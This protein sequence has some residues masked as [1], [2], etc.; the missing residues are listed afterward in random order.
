MKHLKN[1]KIFES[2]D[3]MEFARNIYDLQN[4]IND[5]FFS[6]ISDEDRFSVRVETTS[7]KNKTWVSISLSDHMD[8]EGFRLGEIKDFL[9]RLKG[10]LGDRCGKVGILVQGE[11]ERID[12]DI[13]EKEIDQ[14]DRWYNMIDTPGI[15][16]IFIR[17]L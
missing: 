1:Y 3:P 13:N 4:D 5:I 16:N 6:E 11:T 7:G 2:D 17:V 12:I 15:A 14:I 8:F 9:L 10:Y